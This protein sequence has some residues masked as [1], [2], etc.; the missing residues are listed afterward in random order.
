MSVSNLTAGKRVRQTKRRFNYSSGKSLL[1]IQTSQLTMP[2]T[3]ITAR[4]G[5]FDDENGIYFESQ[6]GL[7]NVVLRSYT[8]GSVVERRVVNTDWNIDS[9]DGNG[10]SGISIDPAKTQILYIDIEWLGVGR[11]RMGFVVDGIVYYC[12]EYLNTNRLDTVYMSTANLPI[13]Y[14]I[15]ND[16][17]GGAAS[18]QHICSTVISEGGGLVGTGINHLHTNGNSTVNCATAG[19]TYVLFSLR[20]KATHLDANV[21][22]LKVGCLLTTTDYGFYC[23]H[24]N[25]TITGTLTYTDRDNSAVQI[26][27]GNG[28]QTLTGGLEYDGEYITSDNKGNSGLTSVD[29][30]ILIG[31]NIDG[32]R[33]ILVV[34]FTPFGSGTVNAQVSALLSWKETL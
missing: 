20:L 28:T 26:A 7:I 1:I 32:T 15:E 6:N 22:P 30:A 19:I 3:G 17:T 14:E 31:A 2:Q 29:N 11:V 16:G 9:M 21:I 18:I 23:L 5:Y 13:R 33:D 24:I 4:V 8:T 34:G 12:H 27:N 25:P 10:A